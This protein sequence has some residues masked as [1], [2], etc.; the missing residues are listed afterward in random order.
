MKI[1]NKASRWRVEFAKKLVRCYAL[2]PGI[3]MILLG[4]SPS[5]GISD[6]Y[7]DLD[8]VMYWNR[9]D[10]KFIKSRPLVGLAAISRSSST[11]ARKARCSRS[12]T[13]GT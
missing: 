6:E 9:L 2:R 1:G 12:T 13:S 8:I 5:R 10:A 11:C 7:S 3:K 4:G